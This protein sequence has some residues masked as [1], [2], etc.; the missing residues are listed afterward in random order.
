MSGGWA[1][2]A[3]LAGLMIGFV[4]GAWSGSRAERRRIVSQAQVLLPTLLRRARELA[5]VAV[6]L[7]VENG[8]LR[9]GLGGVDPPRRNMRH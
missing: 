7:E 1:V 3:G 4:L 5:D 8:Q 6:K 9:A 2:A